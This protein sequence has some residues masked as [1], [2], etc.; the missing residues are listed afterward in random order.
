MKSPILARLAG[1]V[2]LSALSLVLLWPGAAL[3]AHVTERASVS[4]AELQAT[5]ESYFPSVSTDGRYVAFE[6]WAGDLVAGDTNASPDIFV[7]DR[8][9]G[10]I[11]RVSVSS[12]EAQ[13]NHGSGSCS[14]SADGR[15]VAFQSHAS[16]LVTGDSNGWCDIFV[17]DRVLGT[18]ER[19]SV[20]SSEG[21]AN[22]YSTMCSISADGR[23]VAFESNASNLVTGDTNGYSDIFV[24]DRVLG[25]TERVSVT[26]GGS[27]GNSN[28]TSASINA[29]GRYVVFD[30]DAT[31][32]VAGDLNSRS[33][34]F[35]RDRLAGMTVRVSWDAGGTESDGSSFGPRVS[36]SG[37]YV[38]FHSHATDLVPGDTNGKPD[39]FVCDLIT[40]TTE[41]VSVS[42]AETQGNDES[43]YC[44]ISANGRYIAFGSD[45][46]NLGAVDTNGAADIFIHDR[47]TGTTTMASVSTGWIQGNA[48]S[49]YPAISA[50]GRC[51]VFASFA[52]NLVAGDTN[53]TCDAFII[54]NHILVD[55]P[56]ILYTSTRGI[57]RYHTAQL[58]SQA[59]FPT[60][61]PAGSGVVLAPGET[62]QEAL[63]GAPLAAAWGGPVL[64]TYHTALDNGTRDELVRLAPSR[65]FCIGMSSAVVTAV[66]AALPAATITAINGD[67]G[68]VYDMSYR[69]AKAL[70]EK[71]GDMSSAVAIVTVGYNF[72]D[73]LGV[74][75]LVCRMKWPILLTDHGDDSDLHTKAALALSELGISQALKVGTYATLPA[76]ITGIGNLSGADRYY[77]N[78]KVA[79]WAKASAGLSYAHIGI[80]TGDKFPDALASG[81]YLAKDNGLLFLSPL[82]GPWP[83]AV[84]AVILANRAD[85][86]HVSFIAMIEPVITLVK[87]ML[88]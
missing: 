45:A 63:C 60:A 33:D 67:G 64:L 41:R 75:P 56:P 29:D 37:R 39:V 71:V 51:V 15:Y 43:D 22:S 85:V 81:P 17:R 6:S 87:G 52:T 5:G 3:A 36:A 25:T 48:A 16:N 20:S 78:A 12:A 11:E 35:I 62:F 47:D 23:Y 8:A 70:G 30:S 32:L 72:P 53:A 14:I 9:L 46:T 21:Q 58:I 77:T 7:R 88:P 40:W 59:L 86:Q 66:Q 80:A 2:I 18:T 68:S 19:V 42:T 49:A 24:R 83:A 10:T 61:L 50:D 55:S 34:I 26:S 44:C 4:S 57:H 27:Q 82:T 65:V 38:A 1:L 31:N 74:G 73:A 84:G 28:S 79:I 69:V 13:A 76:A 54:S